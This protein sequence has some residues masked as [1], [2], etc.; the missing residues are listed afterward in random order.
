MEDG[1]R[2]LPG[3]AG[4][5]LMGSKDFRYSFS[6]CNLS[7]SVSFEAPALAF[8]L[9]AARPPNIVDLLIIKHIHN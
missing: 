2:G 9:L 3:G 5:R 7:L 1:R 4:L 8:R 6:R